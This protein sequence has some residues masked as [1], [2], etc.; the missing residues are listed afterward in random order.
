MICS[1]SGTDNAIT[2][3][4]NFKKFVEVA[5]HYIGILE[6]KKKMIKIATSTNN[7]KESDIIQF[8]F[9]M[10]PRYFHEI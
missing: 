4:F 6:I 7:E 8:N 3:P 9:R 1:S 5:P 10:S 2:E